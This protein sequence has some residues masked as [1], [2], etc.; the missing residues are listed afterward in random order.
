MGSISSIFNSLC[1]LLKF[2]VLCLWVDFMHYAYYTIAMLFEATHKKRV[3][4]K[5]VPENDRPREKLSSK[6]SENLLDSEL[7]ALLLGTGTQK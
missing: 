6:G 2:A 4:I 3:S 7:I 1:D 5:A